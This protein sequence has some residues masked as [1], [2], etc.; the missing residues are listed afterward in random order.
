MAAALGDS[1]RDHPA[2]TN[3]L[4]AVYEGTQVPIEA[5]LRIETRY[6][7]NTVRAPEA[8]AMV[9]TLFA[10]R[11]ALA[12]AGRSDPALYA[13]RLASA[14]TQGARELVEAGVPASLVRGVARSLSTKLAVQEA[15]PAGASFELPSPEEVKRVR[16]HLLS[17]TAAAAKQALEE[18][19]VATRDE[20]D[21][22][23][24]ELGYPAWT[25]GPMSY[26]EHAGHPSSSH[27]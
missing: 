3:I 9:R 1:S 24:I 17:A 18:R 2:R 27:P 7:F 5:G 23:A 6:F 20:A 15:G 4:R 12:K 11:Q 26:L 13:E 10:A 25:G 14:W 16:D 22:V 19:L 21:L 8:R